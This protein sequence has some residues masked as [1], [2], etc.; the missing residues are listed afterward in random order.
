MLIGFIGI[1]S[2]IVYAIGKNYGDTVEAI[3]FF[4]DVR[5]RS[6]LETVQ[7]LDIQ[8]QIDTLYTIIANHSFDAVTFTRFSDAGGSYTSH[9]CRDHN[10]AWMLHHLS[11][12]PPILPTFCAH[13][14]VCPLTLYY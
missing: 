6:L 12:P 9:M 5:Q 11:S 3:T 13:S 2:I 8:I 1:A 14:L 4:G 7:I 10:S